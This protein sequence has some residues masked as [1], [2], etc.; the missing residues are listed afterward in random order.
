MAS[1]GTT[2]CFSVLFSFLVLALIRI[3]ICV[4][5]LQR[6]RQANYWTKLGIKLPC[7]PS[8]EIFPLEQDLGGVEGSPEKVSLASRHSHPGW[9]KRAEIHRAFNT[10][11]LAFMSKSPASPQKMGCTSPYIEAIRHDRHF[12]SSGLRT[13]CIL[14][15][16]AK[17]QMTSTL[18]NI[19]P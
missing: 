6:Q 18:K 8:E 15:Q 3:G 1:E 12:V 11:P 7:C 17:A 4:C 13:L 5:C 10:A 9:I 2:Q 19:L 14:W 16:K